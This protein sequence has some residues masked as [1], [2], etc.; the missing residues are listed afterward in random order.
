MGQITSLF[1]QSS[2]F[3]QNKQH[4]AFWSYGAITCELTRMFFLIYT[5]RIGQYMLFVPRQLKICV[6]WLITLFQS[7]LYR[8]FNLIVKGSPKF[9]FQLVFSTVLDPNKSCTSASKDTKI[10]LPRRGIRNVQV[11][12]IPMY[13]VSL[14]F[15][16]VPISVSPSHLHVWVQPF[17]YVIHSRLQFLFLSHFI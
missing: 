12:H 5:S 8:T 10:S 2:P 15:E 6:C 13:H 3:S 16:Q 17:S 14:S 7:A 1:P 11:M 9:Y 4:D